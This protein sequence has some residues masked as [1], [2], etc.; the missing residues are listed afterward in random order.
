MSMPIEHLAMLER[1]L[2]ERDIQTVFQPIVSFNGGRIMGHEALSRGPRETPFESPLALFSLAARAALGAA[3]E[4]CACELAIRRFA[5]RGLPGRLFLNVSPLTV[6]RYAAEGASSPVARAAYGSGLAPARVVLEIMEN[7]RVESHV[8]LREA[9][10]RLNALG[11]R[12][13]I[14]DFGDGRSSLRL[15][16]EIAPGL[17]KVDRFLVAGIHEDRRKLECVR[18]I[19]RLAENFGT[20]LICEG[21]EHE[22]ELLV[23]RDLGIHHAQ[24]YWIGRPEPHGLAAVPQHVLNVMEAKQVAVFPDAA[25]RADATATVD[26]LSLPVPPV[27]PSQSIDEV[28]RRFAGDSNLDAIA[29]VEEGRPLGLVARQSFMDRY[30]RPYQKELFGRR[31]CTLFMNEHPLTIER[32]TPLSTLFGVLAGQDQRYL[33]DGFVITE[34]G[35]YHGVGTGESLVRTVTESRVEAARHANPLTLLPGNVPITEHIQ[36]L[37]EARV[38]FVAAYMDL[39]NFK[40]FNDIY[41]YFRGDEM[42]KLCAQVVTS[43]VDPVRD[44]VGHVG[45]DDFVVMLQSADWERRCEDIVASFNRRAQ[46]LFAP[47]EIERGCMEAEDRHGRMT[48]FPLTTVSVGIVVVTGGEFRSAEAVASAAASAKHM[49]KLAQSGM[50]VVRQGAAGEECAPILNEGLIAQLESG[51]AISHGG[52]ARMTLN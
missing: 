26:R 3:L 46:E 35:R 8:R 32:G 18:A 38:S 25:P 2:S 6:E 20:E 37:L 1:I 16:A 15:W 22:A 44:F 41:G 48:T 17:V 51:G 50:H 10:A 43:N 49:A 39:N 52:Q 45:G 36:R 42:I 24:G 47:T 34:G 31:S 13:A 30:A 27:S 5:R 4:D 12:V 29:I 33:H 21:V 40:P 14:D 19:V 23:L 9:V 11:M 7:E 28:A